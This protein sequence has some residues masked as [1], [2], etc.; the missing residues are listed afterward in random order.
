MSGPVASPWC[1]Y[2]AYNRRANETLYAVC[3]GLSGAEYKRDLGAFFGS[4]HGTLNHLLVGDTIWMTRFEG[5]TSPSTG[6]DAILFEKFDALREARERMDRRIERFFGE[7]PA[8]FEAR[9]I[10]YVNNAGIDSTDPADVLLPH[11]FNH[12]THHR[13]QVH[14]MLSQLGHAP[15]V[16]DLHRVLRPN[17]S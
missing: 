15:P 1:H 10:R 3:A 13:A 16:L 6:L 11:F 12:Q 8:G 7:L 4:I 5:G 14:T 9:D 17:P 2:A